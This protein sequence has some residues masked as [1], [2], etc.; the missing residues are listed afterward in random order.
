MQVITL[1]ALLTSFCRN[2]WMYTP[3]NQRSEGEIQLVESNHV[4]GWGEPRLN[5]AV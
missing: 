1:G 5:R 4:N 2:F 3:S